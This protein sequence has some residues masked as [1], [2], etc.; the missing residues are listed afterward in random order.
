MLYF[1]CAVLPA[2][3][4][5]TYVNQ[6]Y[7]C[8]GFSAQATFLALCRQGVFFLPLILVLP[9]LFELAGV[10]AAQPAADL[11]TFLICIP[12]QIVFFRK[13]LKSPA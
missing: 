3:A 1:Y 9:R 6:L 2:M 5:S 11:L 12:F 13:H 4:Y 10:Q 7:Q 8:L